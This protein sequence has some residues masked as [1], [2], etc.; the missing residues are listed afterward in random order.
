MSI[1]EICGLLKSEFMEQGYEYGFYLNGQRIKPDR[2]KG[3]DRDFMH[4]LLTAYRVQDPEVTLREKLG[5][6]V[7]VV[8]MTKMILESH[9][10]ACKVWLLHYL[11]RAKF[12]TI[13][14]FSA[15]GKVVYLE[16]TPQSQKPWYGKEIVF[17]NEGCLLAEYQNDDCEMTDITNEIVAG[18]APAFILSRMT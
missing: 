17:D 10:I 9:G 14:T 2:S 13:L 12:H 18:A 4:S 3:F 5:T 6:C 11:A 1:Q 7:D 8:L 16:L 15:D